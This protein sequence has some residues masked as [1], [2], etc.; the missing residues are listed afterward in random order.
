MPSF[1]GARLL[2]DGRPLDLFLPAESS[3]VPFV[4]P[5]ITLLEAKVLSRLRGLIFRVTLR[6][7]RAGLARQLRRR[8]RRRNH[9]P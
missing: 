8:K 2:L 4:L 5:D 1:P 3:E 7:Q 6:A 9:E